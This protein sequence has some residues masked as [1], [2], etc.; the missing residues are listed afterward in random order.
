MREGS[1]LTKISDEI[2]Q[3]RLPLPFALNHVN[4]YL[5]KAESGW[6]IVD[7]GINWEKGRQTWQYAFDELGFSG[8]DIEQ[9]VLTHVHP[10]HFGLAGWLYQL[11][12]SAGRDI[13]IKTSQREIEQAQ[14][15]WG[16]TRIEFQYWLRDN[17]MPNEMS[18]DVDHSMG[19]TYEMTLPHAP[20]L[21]AL[22]LNQPLKMGERLFKPIIAPGHS[23]GHLLFYDEADKLLL[24]GDHVLM[25]ITPNIGLWENTDP[26]PLGAFMS[27]L[28]DLSGLEVS[29]ALPGHRNIV[30][31]WSGRIAELLLHH[32]HRLNLV[33]E[34]V[35]KG[36]RTP[37]QVANRIFNTERFTTHEWRFAIAETLAHLEYLRVEGK[38]KQADDEQAFSV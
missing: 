37:Y 11:A 2:Y 34:K 17:G 23:D 9:I 26:N 15:V 22:E 27:S 36:A 6:T 31:D 1:P 28:R 32:E 14:A 29:R 12:Q 21:I 33:L 10:D 16:D 13:Q 5:L 7:C 3:L 8:A 30:E 38:I 24:S 19:K 4:A 25:K 35:A 18:D 20:A